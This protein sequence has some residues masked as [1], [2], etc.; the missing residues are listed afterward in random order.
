M[1]G[2]GTAPDLIYARGVP[3]TPAPDKN[4]F[5]KKQRILII[6]EIGFCQNFGCHKR[7]QEKTT[8]YAPLVAA[9]EAMWE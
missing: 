4:T 9:L 2:H 7:L 3:D 8:K 1:E 6:I 5:E